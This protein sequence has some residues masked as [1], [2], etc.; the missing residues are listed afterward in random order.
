MCKKIFLHFNTFAIL[1]MRNSKLFHVTTSLFCCDGLF[2]ATMRHKCLRNNNFGRVF[3]KL[4]QLWSINATSFASSNSSGFSRA[5]KTSFN[6]SLSLSCFWT[7]SVEILFL[8]TL[9]EW[10][11]ETGLDQNEIHVVQ[12]FPFI[13][14]MLL[15]L[16]NKCR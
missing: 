2:F 14:F 5:A 4:I 3:K 13:K 11:Y 10:F 7:P 15:K 6:S 9:C 16:T 1:H 8:G 12:V